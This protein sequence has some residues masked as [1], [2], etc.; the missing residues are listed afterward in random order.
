[1]YIH[2]A[3]SWEQADEAFESFVAGLPER[4][5]EL[6]ERVAASGGPSLDLSVES[7][8]G[9]NAWFIDEV[10]RVPEPAEVDYRSPWLPPSNPD[11]HWEPGKLRP[12]P[13]WLLLLWD[14][15]TAYVGDVMMA[16]VPGA[17]WV[18]WRAKHPGDITNGMPVVDIGVPVRPFVATAC[19]NAGVPGLWTARGVPGR[20]GQPDS[21]RQLD[22]F[23]A[24]LAGRE[25]YLATHP[26]RWQ[27]APTGPRARRSQ[28]TPPG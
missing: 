26:A 23:R 2:A 15:V 13:A 4:R 16:Q 10:L 21:T 3:S 9:L 28:A 5:R 18:C 27:S 20:D 8:G 11:Y 19:A 1:M 14:Q 12:V 22:H 17:R 7:L 24:T 25:T 6:A